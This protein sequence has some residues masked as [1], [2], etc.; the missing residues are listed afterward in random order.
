MSALRDAVIVICVLIAL[1]A[2]QTGL[3][4]S[5]IQPGV[6]EATRVEHGTPDGR[7]VAVAARDVPVWHSA[8]GTVASR[9]RTEV[10][11]RVMAAITS[12]EVDVGDPVEP[13]T[14]LLG[15]DD[16]DL[17]ARTDA[18]RAALAGAKARLDQAVL[19]LDRVRRLVEGSAAAPEELD[20]AKADHDVALATV[21]AMRE[22]VKE[23]EVVADH[24]TILSPIRG[25]VVERLADP[26]DL[27]T[28]GRPLLVLHDPRD[29]R[30]EARV[31][32]GLV[33]G[34]SVGDPVKV[35]LDMPTEDLS[36]KIEEI[37]PAVDP[38]GRTVLVRAALPPR[39]GLHPGLSGQFRFTQGHRRVVAIP[40]DLVRP[41]GTV[42]VLEADGR[43]QVQ[44]VRLGRTCEDRKMAEVLSGL[45]EGETLLAPAGADGAPGA[46]SGAGGV[47]VE[48]RTE[49]VWSEATGTV[50]SRTVTRI[51]PRVMARIEKVLVREGDEVG[52][53]DEIAVLDDRDLRARLDRTRAELTEAGAR[54][55]HAAQV[56]ARTQALVDRGVATNEQL[57]SARAD[58]QTARARKTAAEQ[59]V[60][61][62]DVAVG[63]AVLKSPVAG[64]VVERRA[65]PGALATPGRAVVV[66]HDPTRL[67]FEAPVP[68]RLA[69]LLETGAVVEVD[70]AGSSVT[71]TIDE[72]VPAA[73]PTTRTVLVKASLSSGVGLRPG[74][75]GRLRF[76]AGERTALLVP[77]DAVITV[78]QVSLVR[79]PTAGGAPRVR[80]VRT[81][82][83]PKG[84]LVEVLT[85]LSPGDRVLPGNRV[86]ENGN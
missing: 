28:P 52:I 85:G 55:V 1:V 2:W 16:R 35:R 41:D 26:G 78:G 30:I 18:A 9:T 70:L 6:V 12:V 63:Y 76:R 44:A 34:L 32:E 73:D 79:I 54:L 64:V 83:R 7:T 14:P 53:G 45:R 43:I 66:V 39:E 80:Y 27:A 71:T 75:F 67:R 59:M 65:E 33:M 57:E 22:S 58:E 13:E 31:P 81:R 42:L 19:A 60:Q 61:E 4:R 17:R 69:S 50:R 48:S 40:R 68:E 23:A 62:A 25:V 21:G 11:A 86:I 38:V 37:V 46:T 5:R 47:P 8:V 82:A 49:A 72:V 36:T 10:A 74:L 29:L 77:R 3:G 24:A 84:D 15:L 51:A 56:L 20:A